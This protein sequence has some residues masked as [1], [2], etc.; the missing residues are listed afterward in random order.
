M[1]NSRYK[2]LSYLNL[3]R[4]IFLFLFTV[5]IVVAFLF[6]IFYT[7]DLTGGKNDFT[8]WLIALGTIASASGLIWFSFLTYQNQQNNEFYALFKVLLD[9]HNTLLNQIITTEKENLSFL[10]Q[11]IIYLFELNYRV[12]D[13]TP[14]ESQLSKRINQNYQFKPY[15]ITLFRLLKFIS[16]SHKIDESDKKE[17]YGLVRGLLP[18]EIQFLILFNS[19]NFRDKSISENY[20][21]LII[22]AKLLEHLPIT[23]NW[24]TQLYLYH[25]PSPMESRFW[26]LEHRAKIIAPTL[27][28]YIFSGDLIDVNTFGDSIYLKAYLQK[29]GST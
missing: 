12:E 18:P 17:C 15:L 26:K 4:V 13:A 1:K 7:Y 28:Q 23:T 6:I 9:Q 16:K 21:E 11:G 5:F 22:K 19:L 10:N 24:L 8:N 14:F 27:E 25:S 2:I 29:S 20:T 3:L